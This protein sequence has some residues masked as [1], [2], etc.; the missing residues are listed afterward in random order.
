MYRTSARR[1][2]F[3]RHSSFVTRHSLFSILLAACCLMCA[4]CPQYA[5]PT[6][7]EPIRRVREPVSAGNYFIYVP[8]RY[9]SQ[10][11]V[12]LVV[13]CHGTTPWDTALR[14]IRD[15]VG[16]AEEKNFIVVAPKLKGTRGDLTPSADR[17]IELQNEDE[18]TLLN[19]V[20]HVRGAY[21]IDESRVFLAGWSAGGFAVLYTGLRNPDVFR[22]LAVMQGN[23]NSAFFSDTIGKIDPYQPV[24]VLYGTTDVLTGGEARECVRWLYDQNAYVFDGKVPGPH[25]AHP[26]LAQEFF[27]R[28]IREVPWLRIRAFAAS[29][30][31]SASNAADPYTVRFKTHASFDPPMYHWEFG[32]GESSPIASPT[33]TY[34]E[35]G[36][37]T[38]TLTTKRGKKDLRRKQTI[39][40]PMTTLHHA[41]DE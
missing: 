6:V 1:N 12:P 7:P 40:V 39:T 18:S 35:P 3:I 25:R 17:Q 5:D 19:V 10:K 38:V 36:D 2:P 22:A 11:A 4:G 37:Y 26:E 28:V 33:H 9:D 29:A 34:R 16:L 8:S 20:R 15:W 23:F 13:L 30:E 27:E 24:F 21:S 14:E 31:N 41:L 32:D